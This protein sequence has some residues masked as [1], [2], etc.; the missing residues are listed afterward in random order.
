MNLCTMGHEPIVYEDGDCPLCAVKLELEGAIEIA[1]ERKQKM[2]KLSNMLTDCERIIDQLN[3]VYK[4][5]CFKDGY[6]VINQ[7]QKGGTQ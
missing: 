5:R 7:P 2:D 3:S 6:G 4:L 1:D